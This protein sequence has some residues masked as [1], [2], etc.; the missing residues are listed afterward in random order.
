MNGK[1]KYIVPLMAIQLLLIQSI[2]HA[3][4]SAVPVSAV[5]LSKSNCKFSTSA[6]DLSF[7]TIN[8]GSPSDATAS[9][10]VQFRCMGSAKDATYYISDDDG[11]Y[12]DGPDGNRMR[13]SS[14]AA[15]H[16]RYTITLSPTSATV[17]K[18]T[19]QTLTVNGKVKAADFQ[20]ALAGDYLDT[21]KITISP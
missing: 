18:N 13:H 21:V 11:L 14:V 3:A 19:Y 16:L 2:S 10:T 17:P 1:V 12:E 6:T 7:G 20:N 15:E 9:A 8:P 4:P 5:V